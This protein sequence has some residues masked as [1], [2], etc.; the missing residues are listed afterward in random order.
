MKLVEHSS[1]K[2]NWV[3]PDWFY[4]IVNNKYNF[5]WDLAC[6]THNSKCINGYYYNQGIDSFQQEWH[7]INGYAW[8]NPPYSNAYDWLA[9][10]H[11]ERDKGAKIVMLIPLEKITTKYF[12]DSLPN[13][14]FII[15]GRIQ[16]DGSTSSNTKPSCLCVFDASL[17]TQITLVN[18]QLEVIL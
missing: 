13:Q 12:K 10:A 14:I 4:N 16:F 11:I 15:S 2:D 7:K 3:T 18:Q 1:G 17:P 6:E 5:V 8:C 9:K